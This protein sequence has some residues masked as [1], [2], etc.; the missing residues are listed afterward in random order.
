MA[1]RV[2]DFNDSGKEGNPEDGHGVTKAEDV[3]QAETVQE[4]IG[5]LA[6]AVVDEL[7][8]G[9]N[10]GSIAAARAQAIRR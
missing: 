2:A 4:R 7:Q 1:A 5:K 9:V 3:P 10:V 8:K 6:A